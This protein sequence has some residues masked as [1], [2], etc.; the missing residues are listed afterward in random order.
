MVLRDETDLA[1]IKF[2][3]VKIQEVELLMHCPWFVELGTYCISLLAKIIQ[4]R[5]HSSRMRTTRFSDSRGSLCR[6]P[7]QG[8]PEQRPQTETT[9]TK[10][11]WIVTHMDSDPLGQR[12]PRWHRDPPRRNMGPGSQTGSDITRSPPPRW[13][14]WLTH[15]SELAQTSF[16]GANYMFFLVWQD[17]KCFMIN[18][19]FIVLC[20][21]NNIYS[22]V[23]ILLHLY[24]HSGKPIFDS[25]D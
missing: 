8:P 20:E 25:G 21:N 9:Q 2:L 1:K 14:E 15:T 17:W 10:T 3:W 19:N 11:P 24:L 5:N 22:S 7:R 4:T 16:M 12:P 6:T 18:V 13:T 23:S